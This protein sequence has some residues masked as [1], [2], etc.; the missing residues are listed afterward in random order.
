MKLFKF[1][2][3]TLA[4]TLV[5]VAAQAQF[6]KRLN[7]AV[8]NAAE[9]AAV[10]QA[11]KRTEEAVN[12]GI[13]NAFDKAEEQRAKGEAELEKA[14][15]NAAEKIDDAQKAQ[16][17]ADAMTADIPDAIPE[18]GNTPYTPSESEYTFFAMK[19]GAVQTV[20]TKD[21][22]GKITSQARNT[23]QAITGAKDAFAIDYKSEILD[24]KGKPANKDNPL[25]LN[26]RIVVKDG[27]MYLDMKGMF[28]GIDGLDGVQV[29]G[30]SMKIPGNLAAGQTLDDASAKVRIGFI[31][32]SAVMTEGKCLATEDVTVA[33][34]TFHCYKISQKTNA[35]VMGIRSEGTTFTWYAKGVGAVKT[36]T[37]DKKDKLLSTQELI[38]NQ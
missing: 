14:L 21:A 25:V 26:Y 19:T 5:C 7:N 38:A 4:L 27:L 16:E 32:C 34:G 17:E 2:T 22:K 6:N 35:T 31:N 36:E 23:V 8:K 10:R 15:D 29:S 28:G 24:A 37:Y 13:D 18:V 33:A 11:E 1:V 9:N 12:K 30:K 20:A 3:V